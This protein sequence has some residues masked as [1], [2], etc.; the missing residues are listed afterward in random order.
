MSHLLNTDA[1]VDCKLTFMGREHSFRPASLWSIVTYY[2]GDALPRLKAAEAEGDHQ[3][4][5][6]I[7]IE[8]IRH[9]IPDISEDELKMATAKQLTWIYSFVRDGIPPED[10]E[11]N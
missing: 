10:T 3:K 6:E 11:K 8:I 5:V 1:F 2:E 7:Q 4:Q 9:T